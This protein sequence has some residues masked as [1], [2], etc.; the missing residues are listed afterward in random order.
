MFRRF[1]GA[2]TL[3]L[4]EG[5]C[6]LLRRTISEYVDLLSADST[7]PVTQ[8][9]YPRASTDEKVADEY[10]E[11]IGGTLEAEKRMAAEKVR[12][13]LGESGKR[14]GPVADEDQQA[15]LTVL[16]DVRLA[17]GARIGITEEMM[18]VEPDP[19]DPEQFPLAVL[20]WLAFLQETLVRSLMPGVRI[21][22]PPLRASD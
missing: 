17:I 19:D 7:D 15:W 5:E 18:L 16:T 3:N 10:Q 21:P 2:I 20:H 11:L 8:R 6:D 9:L 14:R 4:S 13:S 1:K 12:W 22:E